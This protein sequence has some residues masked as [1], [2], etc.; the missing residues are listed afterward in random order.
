[1]LDRWLLSR[2]ASLTAEVRG[3]M[4]AYE[5]TK[6]YRAVADFVDDLSNWYV[7]RSRARFWGDAADADARAAFRTLWEAL[8]TVALLIAPATPFFA[9]W[10]HRALTGESVHLARFPEVDEDALDTALETEM[11]SARTLVSLGRAAREEVQIRVRQPLRK[12]QAVVPS[13]IEMRDAVLDL[14]KDEL[15]VKEVGFIGSAEGMVTLH[16][17]PNYRELGPRFGKETNDAANA[18]RALSPEELSTFRDGKEVSFTVN[19]EAHPLRPE[20]LDILEEASGDDI[21]KS[22]GGHTVALDPLLDDELREEG[23]ARELV[24]RIQRLRKDADLEITDRIELG[25]YGGEDVTTAATEWDAFI[26][27]ETLARDLDVGDPDTAEL[28]DEWFA[29]TEVDL[30]GVLAHIGLRRAEG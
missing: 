16:A 26:R 12:I 19:G 29:W 6:A 18:I 11:D 8:R 1:V 20:D 5:P 27:G 7:R 30:D 22:E 28:D 4:D 24:N 15:N 2:M 17:N 3:E 10:L 21:V 13:G 25:V 14:V 9:D 23:L